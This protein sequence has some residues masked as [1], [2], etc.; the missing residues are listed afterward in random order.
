LPARGADRLPTAALAWAAFE[1]FRNPAVV[2]VTIYVFMPY[3]VAAV[4]PDP[5]AGQALVATAGQWS[6]WLVA[7]LAPLFGL[8][9]D[10]FGPKKPFLGLVVLLMLPVYALLWWV[11]PGGPVS[12]T[13]FLAILVASGI[14]FAL[15]EVFH[16]ALL[17]PAAG[18]RAADASGLAL[19]LGNLVSVVMLVALLWGFSLPGSVDWGLVPERPLF[20]VDPAA[21]EPAR[22]TGPIVAVSLGVGLALIL[23]FVPD[24]PRTG[25]SLPAALGAALADLRG[26]IGQLRGQPEAAKFLAARMLYADGK[27][28]ILL[29]G[30]VLAAG[31]MGWGTLEMLAYGILLSVLAVAGGLLAPRLDRAMGPRNAVLLEIGVTAVVLVALLLTAPGRIAGFAV[32][33][34]PLFSGPMFTRPAE[35]GFIA[36]AGLSAISIT[37]AYASS[38]TLLTRLVPPERL[39]TFF[40]LYALS[41]T[42]TA[43]AGPMLVAFGTAWF[44]SQRA[45]VAMVLG[46]LAVGFLLL[47]TVRNPRVPGGT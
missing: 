43:W 27:T 15:T 18:L 17:V 34:A 14:L 44:Q 2:L 13:L 32:S 10:R 25:R 38:R 28:A 7:A 5:V 20:G 26:M 40:G 36:I 37:A 12:P 42:A 46:L 31:T 47:L 39:A 22:M 16:N 19:A 11:T 6:G 33:E 45:G 35:L 30:G 8:A 9:A 4:A 24:A 23:A 41:G 29:F 1:G 21:F 3:Y